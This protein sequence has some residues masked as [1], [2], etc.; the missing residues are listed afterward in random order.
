MLSEFSNLTPSW[1][2]MGACCHVMLL[3]QSHIDRA[4][5][6]GGWVEG[7]DPIQVL[8]MDHF[9]QEV[10]CDRQLY[11]NPYSAEVLLKDGRRFLM[12][13]EGWE[14]LRAFSRGWREDYP[15]SPDPLP[16]VLTAKF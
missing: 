15:L 14:V 8:L 1:E 3:R 10:S 4:E 13:W 6:M 7:H 11:P 12:N 5:L 2:L 16:I 9:L